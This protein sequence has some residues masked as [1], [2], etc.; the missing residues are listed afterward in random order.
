MKLVRKGPTQPEIERRALNKAGGFTLLE[1]M[2]TLALFVMI[3][4]ALVFTS[5]GIQAEYLDQGAYRFETMLR[6]ARSEA[7]NRGRRMRLQF[8]EVDAAAQ[9]DGQSRGSLVITWEPQPLAQPGQF[10]PYGDSSWARQLPNDMIVMVRSQRV[11]AS[12]HQ[13]LAYDQQPAGG[14]VSEDAQPLQSVD[15][16]PDG[17]SD[18]VVFELQSLDPLEVRRA[19]IQMDGVNGIIETRIM[20]PGEMQKYYQDT[21]MDKNSP[22][23]GSQPAY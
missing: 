4:G 23:S 20:T 14:E 16:Y 18:S 22:Q 12:A 7:A 17:S 2:L 9:T 8:E 19:L 5:W 1:V 3:A 10:V 13:V 15:F 21:Q 6:L 11:G